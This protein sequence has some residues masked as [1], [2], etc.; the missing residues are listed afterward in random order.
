MEDTLPIGSDSKQ[1]IEHA[2]MDNGNL[3]NRYHITMADST[4]VSAS[5][6]AQAIK[7]LMETALMQLHNL[8]VDVTITMN[9]IYLVRLGEV[10]DDPGQY[11]EYRVT[12]VFGSNGS[13][14]NT[15]YEEDAYIMGNYQPISAEECPA[16]PFFE[17]YGM[18]GDG[19]GV[20]A[21]A[22]I[23]V[24]TGSGDPYTVDFQI[25]VHKDLSYAQP[26]TVKSTNTSN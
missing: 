23:T 3:S 20:G 22:N 14:T 21:V 11:S 19:N 25:E 10:E 4:Q 13:V 17:S 2:V 15:T 1:W 24:S 12:E 5:S 9:S 7:H 16:I 8:D 26:Y 18:E 6:I